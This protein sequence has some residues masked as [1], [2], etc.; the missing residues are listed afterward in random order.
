MTI[1]FLAEKVASAGAV[2]SFPSV[3]SEPFRPGAFP[4]HGLLGRTT[5]INGNTP[6]QLS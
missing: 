4:L 6:T 5:D 1:F 2:A 3:I